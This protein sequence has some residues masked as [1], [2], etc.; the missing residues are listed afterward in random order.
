MK[1]KAPLVWLRKA[2]WWLRRTRILYNTAIT[3]HQR[4]KIHRYASENGMSANT[5]FACEY[6]TITVFS[7]H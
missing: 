5:Y 4:A 7:H 3:A 2:N 6:L 1:Y